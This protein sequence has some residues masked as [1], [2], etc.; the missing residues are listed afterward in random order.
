MTPAHDGHVIYL[1][2]QNAAGQWVDL[3][4]GS[5]SAASTFTFDYTPGRLGT[6]NL[7][8]QITGGPWNIGGVSATLPLTLSGSAP[9][10]TLPPAS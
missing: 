9:V 8:V 6:F 3:K 4:A 2:E 5:L 10:S 1:Q 7:R